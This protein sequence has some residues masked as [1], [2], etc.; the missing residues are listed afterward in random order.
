MVGV[1]VEVRVQVRVRAGVRVGV[2]EFAL[3]YI[4]IDVVRYGHQA[5][6]VLAQ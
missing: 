4:V 6:C 5:R 1:R 2:K 3:A